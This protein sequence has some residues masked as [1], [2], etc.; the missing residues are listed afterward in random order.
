MIDF[1]GVDRWNP[2]SMNAS[3]SRKDVGSSAVQ[4]E[5]S[6]PN[7]SGATPP[8]PFRVSNVQ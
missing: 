7:A 1:D 6:P 3:R 8:L 2:A 4:P 5:P